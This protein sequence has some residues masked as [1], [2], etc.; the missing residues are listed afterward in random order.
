VANAATALKMSKEAAASGQGDE[1]SRGEAK[2]DRVRKLKIQKS[3]SETNLDR[4]LRVIREKVFACS[5]P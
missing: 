4:I 5:K 3:V 2:K 1:K